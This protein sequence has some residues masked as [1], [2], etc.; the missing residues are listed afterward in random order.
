MRRSGV[1]YFVLFLCATIAAFPQTKE[2]LQKDNQRL[3]EEIRMINQLMAQTTRSAQNSATNLQNLQNKIQARRRILNNI[4]QEI[5][6]LDREI[7][8]KERNIRAMQIELDTLKS[9]YAK[10]CSHFYDNSSDQMRLMY[11]LSSKNFSQAFKRRQYIEQYVTWIRTQGEKILEKKKEVEETIASLRL[12]R[13]DKTALLRRQQEEVSSIESESA[14]ERKLLTSLQGKKKQLEA[15]LKSKKAIAARI[16]SEI[17]RIIREE[18][19]KNKKT[20]SSKE[21]QYELTPAGQKLSADFSQN[22]G[23][24]PWPVER[25]VLYSRFG[26]Q[27]YPG[28]KNVFIDNLGVMIATEPNTP[29]RAVFSGEVS[30]VQIIPGSNYAV[31]LKHGKYITVYGNLSQVYVKQGDSV[32]GEEKI[33]LIHTDPVENKTLLNFLLFDGTQR[34]NPEL[35]LSK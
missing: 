7:G 24:L 22:R 15:D 2:S 14:Q 12:A 17:E 16:E 3:Q 25:G 10:M 13:T 31:Y 4:S 8:E 29:A 6:L 20:S 1:F 27:E 28:L 34:Q 21:Q 5:S 35:W 11:L 32:R 33:G 19:Q 30:R 26:R 23:K 18:M 9:R